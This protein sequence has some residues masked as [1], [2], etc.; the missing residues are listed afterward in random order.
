MRG[1]S[2]RIGWCA[3]IGLAA[4]LICPSPGRALETVALQLKWL[5]QFQFAGYYA[6]LE[7]G[8]YRE[9]GFDAVLR[10]GGPNIDPAAELI[11][12]RADYGVCNSGLLLGWAQG[13]ELVS[14]AAIFQHSPAQLLVARR[15]D[16][17][18]LSELRDRRLMDAPGS[19]EVAAM[20]IRAGVD[21]AAMIRVPHRGDPRDLLDGKAEA[22]ISYATNEPF[23]LEQMGVPYRTF[24]PRTVGI[25]FYGDIL[26]ASA[27]SARANPDRVDAFRDASLRGWEYALSHQEEIVDL[28][29]SR[30]SK[31][32]T[33]EALLFE[34]AR[35]DLLVRA[36][37]AAIGI[38]TPDR[39]REIGAVYRDLGYPVPEEIP[40]DLIWH[41]SQDRFGHMAMYILL[42]IG[43]V[44]VIG[45]GAILLFRHRRNA[46]AGDDPLRRI[47][48]VRLSL[49][50]AVLFVGL[51]IP[52]LIFILIYN[53]TRNEDA[54][55]GILHDSIAETSR[56]GIDHTRDLI[57][58][59][60]GPLLLL[61]QLAAANPD[62]F[63]QEESRNL[64]YR[65]LTAAPHI[66]A[67]YVSFEDGY[68]RVVTRIDAD[69]RR[70]E[71]QIPDSANWH[72][73]YIDA[74]TD[75]LKRKRHRTFFDIWPHEVGR[76]DV[77]TS[78]NVP[79]LP[80]YQEAKASAALAMTAPTINPDTGYPILSVRVPIITAEGKFLG[81]V[82]A[83][84]TMDTLSRFLDENR[85]SRGSL[86]FIADRRDGRIIAHPDK[87]KAVRV[88]NGT[89]EIATLATS[90]D[91]VVREAGRQS[92]STR[93]LQF[94]FNVPDDGREMIAL[95][96]NF[97]DGF[98]QPWQV[99]TITPVDD[100]VGTLRETNRVMMIVILGLAL[101][102]S[103]VIYIAATRLARPVEI[104]SQTLR[105]IEN[106]DFSVTTARQSGIR[107]I[108][109]LESA[110]GLLRN[111][112]R[113]FASF[114][115]LDVVRHL[116]RSGV[117][118]APGVESRVLTIFFSD[119]ENFSTQAEQLPPDRLLEQ[120]SGYLQTVCQA[121]A[122]ESGTVDKFIGDGVM[123]FWGA[124]EPR[125]D[126]AIRGCVAALRASR[127][128]ARLNETWADTGRP[129]MRLRVGLNCAKV[130]VGNVGSSERLSYTALGD[131]V[132][133]AA[134]LEGLNKELGTSICI[135]DTL[136]EAVKDRAVVR[137][138]KR[139]QVKGR[140]THFMV[141][142]LLGIA[143]SDDPELRA[144]PDILELGRLTAEAMQR[145]E[146]GD[147]AAAGAQYAA[148]LQR[149]P[150][151][152]VARSMLRECGVPAPA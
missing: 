126:H 57:N 29:L 45:G 102:E 93:A 44:A 92:Q 40:E 61:A 36:E 5:H 81:C 109:E 137:P 42:A 15:G 88:H 41:H 75:G 7:K 46:M 128:M 65:V 16:F 142:E 115:P 91:P 76:Y 141:Y 39:W 59:T 97:P 9:A 78:L 103:I 99:V 134:R 55:V 6:A 101:I 31:A 2:G 12:G 10:E 121:I 49:V 146:A 150:D 58:D 85:A 20:L 1:N 79:A 13:R 50:M 113:S 8:F 149:F 72:S 104:V 98:G 84:I 24:S 52:V 130:L 143:D 56:I 144:D 74:V 136:Y 152:P 145:F 80:G 118:L 82:S 53:Y 71:P 17:S 48:R 22:M 117:P 139:A 131:G 70:S 124:P 63:R 90:D 35:T 4:L 123:A 132:N 94:G 11:A 89:L 116:V 28:I 148:I 111:S 21:Y 18:S 112:L 23:V 147:R 133:V 64:L 67:A 62:Y 108:A 100:F 38:Q 27:K 54:I 51:S 68:H 125:E 114:V 33:R 73:S 106:L 43:I 120:I 105:A 66:D 135:S 129:T 122:E 14:L 119:L 34:A 140:K 77:D 87:T 32:K 127:R 47:L 69:R 96:N 19:D 110:A 83:N 37:T 138:V 3:A 107:E 26:C 86:T 60:E 30:Y 25:D 151:D 95:F